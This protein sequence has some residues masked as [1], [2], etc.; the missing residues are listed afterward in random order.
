MLNLARTYDIGCNPLMQ[1]PD[2]LCFNYYKY[3]DTYSLPLMHKHTKS[4]YSE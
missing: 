4:S 2:W 3:H 1:S